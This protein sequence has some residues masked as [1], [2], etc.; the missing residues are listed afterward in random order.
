LFFLFAFVSLATHHRHAEQCACRRS[1]SILTLDG[2]TPPAVGVTRLRTLPCRAKRSILTLNRQTPPTVGVT[3]LRTLSCRAKRSIFTLNGQTPPA[4]GVTRLRTLSCRAKRSIFT[5]NGRTPPLRCNAAA[6]GS[7]LH[8]IYFLSTIPQHCKCCGARP[9]TIGV[10]KL[11]TLSC[12]AKHLPAG[13]QE[14][15]LHWMDRLLLRS[16]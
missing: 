11:R 15:S 12:G 6:V 10:T 1:G 7:S 13:G 4:V 5:L 3:R 16:E 8:G 9:P 14:A 2:Q